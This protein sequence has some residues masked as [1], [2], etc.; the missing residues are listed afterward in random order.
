M[1]KFR[2]LFALALPVVIIS[3]QKDANE[4]LADDQEIVT[5][6]GNGAPSGAHYNLNIIGVPKD[7]SPDFT[8]GNGHRIFVDLEGRT[9]IL[10][11]K[12]EFDV[13]DANGTD[14]TA[15]FQLPEPDATD[16]GI[17]DYS[18]YVRGLGK[19]GGG[20]TMT[21]CYFDQQL[22]TEYCSS[23]E[24]IVQISS[25]GN[26]NKFQNVTNQLLYVWADIDG[27][28]DVDRT[29]LFSDPLDEYYWYYDNAGLKLAQ[30]RFY[31]GVG[32]P[33]WGDPEP[34]TK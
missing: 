17:T 7:K 26:N 21:S 28:G 18:V 5:G 8:G 32:T 10:L 11:R 33:V 34:G 14:G 15:A 25:H 1:R 30:L 24:Y 2:W 27:D 20:A 22:Q 13:L 29:E 31:P 9:K 6:K 3:C 23:G 19:P 4:N 12:G 16:D